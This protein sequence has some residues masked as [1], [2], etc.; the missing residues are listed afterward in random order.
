VV[1]AATAGTLLFV[2]LTAAIYGP[3]IWIAYVK[4]GLPG[5]IVNIRES[6][7]LLSAIS[8][9]MTTTMTLLGLPAEIVTFVQAIFTLIAILSVACLGFR[10]PSLD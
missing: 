6:A 4:D 1:A 5:Q 8:P 7:S 9:T 10:H 2:L 3:E